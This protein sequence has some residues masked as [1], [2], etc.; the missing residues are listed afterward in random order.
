MK[1]LDHNFWIATVSSFLPWCI[2]WYPPEHRL[3]SSATIYFIIDFPRSDIEWALNYKHSEPYHYEDSILSAK[4]LLMAL[5]RETT[6]YPCQ[7]QRSI[8]CY[9]SKRHT[10]V[11]LDKRAMS[12]LALRGL[13]LLQ[14]H[15][16]RY[17]TC[18]TE[19][20]GAW[21]TYVLKYSTWLAKAT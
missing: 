21:T 14:L 20:Q 7:I 1:F 4:N 16:C 13:H 3:T 17:R 6:S 19:I 10:T 2:Y 8:F 18:G 12:R 5:K 15:L 9:Q 11:I